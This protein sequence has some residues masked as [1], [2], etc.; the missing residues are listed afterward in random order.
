MKISRNLKSMTKVVLSVSIVALLI[1]LSSCKSKKPVVVNTPTKEVKKVDTRVV[2]AKATLNKLLS[3]TCTKSIEEKEKILADIKAQ[4]I[5]N[6]EV[7][8]LISQVEQSIAKEK[9]A[10]AEAERLAKER[11]LAEAEAAK[12][13]NRL[14][15]YFDKIANAP[16]DG[17]ANQLISQALGMF[18]SPESNV[19]V[20]ISEENG[21]KDYDRPTKIGKYLNYLKTTKNNI[22]KI[23]EIKWAGDKI[24]TLILR[25]MR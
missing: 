6:D 21:Q 4:N 23:E 14:S 17:A 10:K 9:E 16:S 11:A 3:P 12:P 5:D 15:N 8:S 18:T 22:N 2:Q 25:K 13:A 20:I 7:R 19:L 1:G 24:K